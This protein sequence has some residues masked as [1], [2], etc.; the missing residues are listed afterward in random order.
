MRSIVGEL[1]LAARRAGA[2]VTVTVIGDLDMATT[3]GLRDFLATALRE[4]DERVS[5]DLAG[6][7]FIDAGGIGVLV[8]FRNRTRLQGTQLLLID[9]SDCVRHLL[10]ITGLDGQFPPT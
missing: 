8:G 4:G 5:L 2:T 6:L 3:P 1:C 7:T 9:S 10:C